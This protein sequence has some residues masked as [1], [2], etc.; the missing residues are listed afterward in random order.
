[1]P[2]KGPNIK[3]YVGI[4]LIILL[5]VIAVGAIAF[6]YNNQHAPNTV[7]AAPGVHV[8]DTFDYKLMGASILFSQNAVTPDYLYQYNQTDYFRITITEVNGTVV[9]FK[10]DWKYLNGTNL[11]STQWVNV[12]NGDQSDSNGFWGIYPANLKVGD[13]T[14][15]G[16]FDKITVNQTDTQAY[17]SSSRTRDYF[18]V[19]NQFYDVTDPTHS[20][21]RDEFDTV[22]FDQQTGMLQSLTNI[23]QYNNPQYNIL[24]TWKLSAS[25]V[26]AVQ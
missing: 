15:P 1:M 2:K 8:G 5:V 17:A 14:R 20:T 11:Q 22:W 7:N 23:Q 18:S 16:G 25:S 19:S 9:T 12:S 24:I 6:V 3:L 13:L 10:T 4:T 26:W 21:F